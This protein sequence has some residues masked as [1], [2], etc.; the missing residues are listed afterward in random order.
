MQAAAAVESDRA[1]SSPSV[2]VFTLTLVEAR[3]GAPVTGLVPWAP[4]FEA[5]CVLCEELG[6]VVECESVAD[7][8][9]ALFWQ[10]RRT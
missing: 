2:P 6:I 10:P 1:R 5:L 9:V 8:S 7:E 4:F 3:T